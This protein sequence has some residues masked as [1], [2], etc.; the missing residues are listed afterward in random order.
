MAEKIGIIGTGVISSSIVTGFCGKG[1]NPEFF[2]SPRNAGRA[3]GLAAQ[4]KN[5]YVCASNQEVINK[6]DWIIISVLPQHSPDILSGL[7]FSEDKRII[8]LMPY[9][10]LS[11][12][13]G[14][15]GSYKSIARV[16]PLPFI[17]EGFGPIA[18]YPPQPETEALFAPLGD[19]VTASSDRE[20][21]IIAAITALMAPFYTH[22]DEL[23]KWSG[24]SGLDMNSAVRYSLS[25]FEALCHR[26]KMSANPA[27]SVNFL[28]GEF[29]PGGLNEQA[30]NEIGSYGGYAAW[31]SALDSVMK[32][33][34]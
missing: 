26:A 16:I 19:I 12:I 31:T 1:I 27:E 15:I 32:R 11:E 13:G 30:K 22:V 28:A 21:S 33:L 2:L 6:S 8:N 7:A 29:T 4:H 23:V 24:E 10:A 17:A 5:V 9:P 14:M 34:G 3:A 20:I 18:I 25:F